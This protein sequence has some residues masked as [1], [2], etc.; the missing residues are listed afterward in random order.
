MYFITKINTLEGKLVLI[1]F[2]TRKQL[3]LLIIVTSNGYYKKDLTFDFTSRGQ[4]GINTRVNSKYDKKQNIELAPQTVLLRG[5]TKSK[6]FGL[7][8]VPNALVHAI[9]SYKDQVPNFQ[10]LRT[11]STGFGKN[12]DEKLKLSL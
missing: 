1:Q 10:N 9:S 11:I 8:I 7:M 2:W 5:Q 12:K 4:T 3:I 6:S